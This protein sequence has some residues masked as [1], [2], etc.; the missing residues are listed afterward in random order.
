MPDQAPRQREG[1][2]IESA[3]SW[4]IAVVSMLVI[5][6]GWGAPYLIAVALK[7]MAADLGS[8]RSVPS[9]ASSFA[10]IGIGVGGIFMGWWADRVGAMWTALLGSIM[11]GAGAM[12]A[13]GGAEWQL[14]IGYGV[15]IGLFG[16]AGLF[17]P[18]MA[19]TSRWFHARRGT[20]LAIVA[21]GQQIA[22]ACWPLVF[23]FALDRV[24]WRT[25]LF[26]YGALVLAVVPA[27]CLMLRHRPP[28]PAASAPVRGPH[29]TGRPPEFA[30]NA[31]Q[32]VLCAAIVCCCVPMALPLAHL[33]AFC[34]DLGYAPARGT[35]ML[36]LLLVA[37][38]LSRMIWGRMSD[39][40]G[41]LKTIMVGSL[42]QAV[43]L[44]CYL[45]V[46]NLVGLY[47]VSAAFGV[48]F[49]GIIPSYV[50][51]VRDLFPASEAGWRIGTVLLFGLLGMALGAWMGGAIYD[52]FAYYKPAFAA[53]VAFNIGNLVLIG[54]LL[55]RGT[56]RPILPIART[57]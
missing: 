3:A 56:R 21:S 5:S 16:G 47:A 45:F 20:A 35:E 50:L 13:S 54:S 26:W 41:G 12:V 36:T 32:A 37:A 23:R 30:S 42:A 9:L 48:G 34:S 14:Y 39:R 51:T 43:F 27:L 28:V 8:A 52:W 40:I 25:T 6:I 31:V 55:A 15:M 19:N 11:I 49:G 4:R 44:A 22:G 46:D 38:F 29:G 10:Y 1:V 18:L 57:A 2:I 24:G 33:V 53:G 17:A 7:P